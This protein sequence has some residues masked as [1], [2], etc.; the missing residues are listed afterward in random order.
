MELRLEP[1][2]EAI[3]SVPPHAEED[4]LRSRESLSWDI[5]WTL[6]VSMP[7]LEN[8]WPS[9][10]HLTQ[11]TL[12]QLLPESPHFLFYLERSGEHWLLEFTGSSCPF[13]RPIS[14]SAP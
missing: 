7:R 13:R 2:S 14:C 3:K 11:L 5:E 8:G 9:E 6:L 12:W 10:G 1:A 4:K